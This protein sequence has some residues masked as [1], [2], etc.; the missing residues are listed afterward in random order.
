MT[1]HL[2]VELL[3]FSCICLIFLIK[4]SVTPKSKMWKRKIP[5]CP[6]FILKYQTETR[7]STGNLVNVYIHLSK[8]Y[9]F[10][11]Q[12]KC[13]DNK[14]TKNYERHKFIHQ[15]MKLSKIIFAHSSSK[16]S[17]WNTFNQTVTL[18]MWCM[19]YQKYETKTT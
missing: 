10:P 15:L 1:R 4:I 11:C 2:R 19:P 6:L 16:N 13:W 3:R 8:S 7:F 9:P 18:S 12:A 17:C 14:N 5:S